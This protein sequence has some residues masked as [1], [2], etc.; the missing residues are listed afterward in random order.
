MLFPGAYWFSTASPRNISSPS[1]FRAVFQD[2]LSIWMSTD[3]V[4]SERLRRGPSKL[5][6]PT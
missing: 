6:N 4:G 1:A 2:L 3:N 5:P